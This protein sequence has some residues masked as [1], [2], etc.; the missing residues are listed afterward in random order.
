[1]MPP[2]KVGRGADYRQLGGEATELIDFFGRLDRDSRKC[3][4]DRK[5]QA[6]SRASGQPRAREKMGCLS[7]NPTKLVQK[8]FQIK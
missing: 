3:G 6:G 7:F 1:M 5:K 2:R 4:R 8:E